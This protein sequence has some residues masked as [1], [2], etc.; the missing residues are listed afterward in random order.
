MVSVRVSIIRLLT[1]KLPPP[2][3]YPR[4]VGTFLDFGILF[5]F[6][7]LSI[8]FPTPLPKDESQSHEDYCRYILSVFLA[9]YFFLDSPLIQNCLY[10][11]V[12][13][14]RNVPDEL[15]LCEWLVLFFSEAS[16]TKKETR[17]YLKRVREF[18]EDLISLGNRYIT[19]EFLG[20]DTY[21]DLWCVGSTYLNV[22]H[23]RYPSLMLDSTGTESYTH[24]TILERIRMFFGRVDLDACS[25]SR[26]N[27]HIRALVYGNKDFDSRNFNWFGNVFMNPPFVEYVSQTPDNDVNYNLRNRNESR[28]RLRKCN[29]TGEWVNYAMRQVEDGFVNALIMLLPM[30]RTGW[31]NQLKDQLLTMRDK[32]GLVNLTKEYSR[33]WSVDN[34]V[35]SHRDHNESMQL[36]YI[37]NDPERF[38][39]AFKVFGKID[40]LE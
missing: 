34:H 12:Q 31:R 40:K 9:G 2:S 6:S 3:L 37:G 26:S 36:I 8:V 18:V 4:F 30:R 29:V 28:N 23:L 17:L 14:L 35:S 21:F 32:V 24:I 20:D 1:G 22:S 11:V 13:K 10:F 39:F 19:N 16:L 7:S 27:F 33:V 5:N 15:C 38:Q 25:N